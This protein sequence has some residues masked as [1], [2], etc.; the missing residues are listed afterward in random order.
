[1]NNDQL[2]MSTVVIDDVI[3]SLKNGT[4]GQDEKNILDNI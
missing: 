4:L 2:N 3:L 1:M